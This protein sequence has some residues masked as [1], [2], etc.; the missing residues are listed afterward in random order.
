MLISSLQG[1]TLETSTTRAHRRA[2]DLRP[3]VGAD[4]EHLA[5]GSSFGFSL[6]RAAFALHRLMVSDSDRTCDAW[7]YQM[8]S[9][10]ALEQHHLY[11]AM[12][13]RAR[14]WTTRTRAAPHGHSGVPGLVLCSMKR[15]GRSVRTHSRATP[16]TSIYGERNHHRQRLT[17]SA[18]VAASARIACTGPASAS[19]AGA[20]ERLR[21]GGFLAT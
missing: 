1:G 20:A 11:R 21:C 3:A 5:A 13:C 14:R 9:V 2:V 4:L 19:A 17:L 10:D 6:E 8:A 15:A 7:L 16:P 18:A 12:V